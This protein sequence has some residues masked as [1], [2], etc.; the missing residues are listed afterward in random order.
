MNK[1][2]RNFAPDFVYFT[3]QYVADYADNDIFVVLLLW[4]DQGATGQL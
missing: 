2:L 3:L 1:F 4:F